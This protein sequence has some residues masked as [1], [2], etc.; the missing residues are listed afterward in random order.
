M[1]LDVYAYR[2]RK[3]SDEEIKDI[4]SVEEV[5]ARGGLEA[6]PMATINE[7]IANGNTE[8][9]D[10]LPYLTVKFL[11]STCLKIEEFCD[12]L[13]IKDTDEIV[14]RSYSADAVSYSIRD[15]N[16]ENKSRTVSFTK[17]EFLKGFCE[18]KPVEVGIFEIENVGYWRK[19][20][21]LVDRMEEAYGDTITNCGYHEMNEEM[22]EIYEEE[23]EHPVTD[24]SD[25]EALFFSI[26][27]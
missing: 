10:L 26:W 6:L 7:S 5:T 24:L 27:Y 4:T 16:T 21:D 22:I 9:R 19:N 1:G 17:D 3:V 2:I 11:D 18:T 25:D 12:A 23:A 14:G 8:Y 20:S 15:V 13:G